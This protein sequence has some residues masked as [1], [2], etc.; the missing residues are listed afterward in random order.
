MGCIAK[1]GD[2]IAEQVQDMGFVNKSCE[3]CKDVNGELSEVAFRDAPGDPI[4]YMSICEDCKVHNE[5]EGY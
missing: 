2:T 4:Y 3:L 1:N 5:A